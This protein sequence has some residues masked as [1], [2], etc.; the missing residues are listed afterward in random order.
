VIA[1][2]TCH[3]P[4]GAD[5]L[6]EIVATNTEQA[7]GELVVHLDQTSDTRVALERHA[8]CEVTE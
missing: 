2:G 6:V 3:C 1:A 7:A 5:V 8:A 4:C